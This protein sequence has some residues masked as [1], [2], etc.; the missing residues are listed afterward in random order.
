LDKVFL[1]NEYMLP[2]K[3][4]PRIIVDAGANIGLTTVYYANNYPDARI[5][6]IEPELA[7]FEM[8]K[9]NC[10]GLPNVMLM[11]AAIWPQKR[12]LRI[13]NSDAEPWAFAVTDADT[14][15][16]RAV[17]AAITMEEVFQ[18][19]G[20][21]EIDLLKLDIEGSELQLFSTG[22]ERWIDRVQA[23]VI[24]LHDRYRPGCARAFYSVLATRNFVQEI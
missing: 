11:Q 10:A 23:I 3:L 2:F 6:S 17:V 1:H 9:R 24:E 4:S 5:L 20:V 16:S 19:L 18:Q 14:D 8:L 13:E 7:N 15:N 22:A 12:S 21:D